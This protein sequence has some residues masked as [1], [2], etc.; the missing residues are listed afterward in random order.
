[1]ASDAAD[2]LWSEW[3]GEYVLF[4]KPSGKTHFLNE[5]AWVLL[6]DILR[7]PRDLPATTLELANRRGVAPDEDLSAYVSSLVLRFEE[8]GL[9]RRT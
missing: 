6:S 9:T 4:H 7:E 1:M 8:L 2:L 3:D 5:S